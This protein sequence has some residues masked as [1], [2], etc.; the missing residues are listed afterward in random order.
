MRSPDNAFRC[1]P[2]FTVLY[3]DDHRRTPAA[4]RLQSFLNP[5]EAMMMKT[6]TN[7][8][9]AARS[10]MLAAAALVLATAMGA[11]MAQPMSAGPAMHGG[12]GMHGGHGL[13]GGHMIGPMLDAAGATPEQRAKVQQIMKAAHD[14]L[15]QQHQAGRASQQQLA[16]LLTA[17]Q[18][19]PAAIEAA[20]QR[21]SAQRDAASKRMTQAMLDASAVLTPEQRQKVAG[22]MNMRREMME[23]HRRE[24][25]A[26]NPAHRG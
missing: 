20:R 7:Q 2:W 3:G 4:T 23:R 6:M 25:D 10:R 14:E 17:P 5:F 8:H 15:R 13:R 9:W 19:D 21:A 12:P 11:A 16:Q 22:Q 26:M 18:L 24:R 1:R